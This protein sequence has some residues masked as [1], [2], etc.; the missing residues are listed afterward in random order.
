MKSKP[1]LPDRFLIAW[2]EVADDSS[3]VSPVSSPGSLSEDRKTFHPVALPLENGYAAPAPGP[4]GA[5]KSWGSEPADLVRSQR[6]QEKGSPRPGRQARLIFPLLL[7]LLA[8]LPSCDLIFGEPTMDPCDP[9]HNYYEGDRHYIGRDYVQ[10]DGTLNQEKM[11]DALRPGYG[12]CADPLKIAKEK[13][14]K[15]GRYPQEKVRARTADE[16]KFPDPDL[17]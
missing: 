4:A 3:R 14:G 6:V 10:E 7:I 15:D 2:H 17:N 11:L 5:P 8:S 13:S 9:A 12:G 1:W 16:I